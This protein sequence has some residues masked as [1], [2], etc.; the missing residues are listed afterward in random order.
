[1]NI[2]LVCYDYYYYCHSTATIQDSLSA[3]AAPPSYELEDFMAAKF[4]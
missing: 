1:M 4:C 2:L 3:L